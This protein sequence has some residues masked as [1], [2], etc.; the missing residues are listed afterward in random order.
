MPVLMLPLFLLSGCAL[1]PLSA[2]SS[3]ISLGDSSVSQ[4]RESYFWGKLH[5]AEISRFDQAR[6]AVKKTASELGLREKWAEKLTPHRSEMAFVDDDGAQIGVRIDRRAG[7]LVAL[8]IDVGWFG[9]EVT[10]RLFLARLRAY[11]PDPASRPVV[12]DGR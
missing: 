12:A 9:S 11:L 3:I 1:I 4:G 7:N 6:T 5:T 10:D 2:V 8:R